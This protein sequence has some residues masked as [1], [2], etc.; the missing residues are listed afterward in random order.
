[1]L[2]LLWLC[3]SRLWQFRMKVTHTAKGSQRLTTLK[4]MSQWGNILL[5]TL[6]YMRYKFTYWW[7]EPGC[8][9]W[10]EWADPYHQSFWGRSWTS[11]PR[12]WVRWAAPPRCTHRWSGGSWWTGRGSH[13]G[14]PWRP[15]SLLWTLRTPWLC[16]LGRPCWCWMLACPAEK[17]QSCIN[18]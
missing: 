18:L 17:R 8:P 7:M 10:R 12:P 6:F 2:G 13:Y 9:R 15:H 14:Q 4:I 11:Q 5:M 1:M 16:V 3:R